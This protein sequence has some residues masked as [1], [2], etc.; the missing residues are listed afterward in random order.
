MMKITLVFADRHV[1]Y[2]VYLKGVRMR[3]SYLLAVATVLTLLLGIPQ[4]AK[5]G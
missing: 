5:C 4:T 3:K 2:Y 1:V